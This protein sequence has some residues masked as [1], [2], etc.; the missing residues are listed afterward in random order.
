MMLPFQ[1]YHY[2]DAVRITMMLSASWWC[3][4]HDRDA[5]RI[6]MMLSNSSGRRLCLF[7]A[8]YVARNRSLLV[9]QHD[10]VNIIIF[11][12]ELIRTLS[13]CLFSA[14]AEWLWYHHDAF[15]IIMMLSTSS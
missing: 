10:A 11:A 14:H 3:C 5:V 2:H 4:P 7:S 12:A 15:N 8:R 1:F 13:S 9:H 6:T